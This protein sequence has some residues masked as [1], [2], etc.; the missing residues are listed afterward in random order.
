MESIFLRSKIILLGFLLLFTKTEY[1]SVDCKINN[2]ICS[3]DIETERLKTVVILSISRSSSNMI[4]VLTETL[5]FLKINV[6]IKIKIFK[7]AHR[8]YKF[9]ADES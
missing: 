7:S 6:K 8:G 3:S 4:L 1:Q 5:D 2:F 9:R